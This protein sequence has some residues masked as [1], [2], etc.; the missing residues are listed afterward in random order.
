[1]IFTGLDFISCNS[2]SSD[3]KSIAVLLEEYDKKIDE[4]APVMLAMLSGDISKQASLI[5]IT[6]ELDKIVEKLEANKDKMSEEEYMEYI[7]I[8]MKLVSIEDD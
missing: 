1:L 2:N 5:R 8:S 4:F 7:R 3:S 6:G